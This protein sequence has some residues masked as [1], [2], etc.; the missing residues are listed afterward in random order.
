MH[1]DA[2]KCN[3]LEVESEKKPRWKHIM[4]NYQTGKVQKEGFR[5]D[6]S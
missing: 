3:V 5:S 4:G 2:T 6:Q 1:N